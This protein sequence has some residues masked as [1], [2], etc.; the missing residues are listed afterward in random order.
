VNSS[1]ILDRSFL[2][3][4][5]VIEYSGGRMTNYDL[6]GNIKITCNDDLII[7]GSCH[8]EDVLII[9][10]NVRF[11]EGFKGVVHVIATD[12]ISAEKGTV[13]KYPSSFVLNPGKDKK[14]QLKCIQLEG[15][16]IFNGGLIALHPDAATN[17]NKVF[18]RLNISSEV[19]G[20][21]YSA[22]Y[23]HLEGKI[24]A[25]VFCNTLL[26][27]TPSAV[28]ENHLLSCT[29]DPAVYA[30]LMGIPNLLS[31]EPELLLCKN[32]TK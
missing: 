20:F 7:D 19:N 17:T 12:S 1:T 27:K 14:D 5:I 10:K 31:K 28:Y 16:C 25:N 4:G 30:H 23:L 8:F 26:L 22:D 9:A 6:R 15:N 2:K 18:I 29:I 3:P 32:F 24:N 21:I 11:K 13:F